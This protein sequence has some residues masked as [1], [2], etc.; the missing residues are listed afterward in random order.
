MAASRSAATRHLCQ[1]CQPG[2]SRLVTADKKKAK[3][4]RATRATRAT[5][6]AAS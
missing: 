6:K 5:R 4:T 1:R 3:K 2:A